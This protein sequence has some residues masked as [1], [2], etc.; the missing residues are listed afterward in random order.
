MG[1]RACP[2]CLQPRGSCS[3]GNLLLHLQLG[4]QLLGGRPEHAVDHRLQVRAVQRGPDRLTPHAPQVAAGDR[5]A[6]AEE[7]LGHLCA[8]RPACLCD[9]LCSVDIIGSA[10]PRNCLSQALKQLDMQQV[11]SI[12]Q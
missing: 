1:V 10:L 12:A 11:C 6:A 5:K 7:E 3:T 9:A 8:L 2:R 4:A